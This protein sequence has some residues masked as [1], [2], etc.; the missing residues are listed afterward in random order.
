M[1]LFTKIGMASAFAI[2]AMSAG[3]AV[4]ATYVFVGSWSPYNDAAPL[5]NDPAF[6][7]DGPL[8]YTAQEAAALLFGGSASDYAISTVD[9]NP[10]NIDFQAWYDTIG[11]GGSIRAHDFNSKYLGL[12]Y[13]PQ[14]GPWPDPDGPSSAFIRDNFVTSVNYAFRVV[15]EPATWAMMIVGFGLVGTGLRSRRHA[16]A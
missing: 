14:S 9:P 1:K 12:Y 2:A 8:A 10:G 7:P 16:T 15:P 3:S 11:W 5:W 6:A 4:A 13:G